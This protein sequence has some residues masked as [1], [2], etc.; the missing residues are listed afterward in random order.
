MDGD[1]VLTLADIELWK[2][3]ELQIIHAEYPMLSCTSL[4]IKTLKL[5]KGESQS[6]S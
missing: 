1:F 4:Y 3:C 2:F 5:I 6:Y